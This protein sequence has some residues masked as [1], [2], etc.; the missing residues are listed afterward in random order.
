[1]NKEEWKS[2]WAKKSKKG[3]VVRYIDPKNSRNVI[4]QMPGDA[5]SGYPSQQTPYVRYQKNGSFYDKNGK[6]SFG[7]R[8]ARSSY[9]FKR[10][11][12]K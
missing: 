10:V 7:W 3:G 6:K 12:S 2:F 11:R 8:N 5:G 9:S 1:M 4:R